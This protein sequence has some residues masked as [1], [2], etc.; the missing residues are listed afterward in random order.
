MFKEYHKIITAWKRD[1]VTKYKTLI[2]GEWA[3]PEFEYLQDAVWSWTEKV[4]GTNIRLT[5]ADG[6]VRLDGRHQRSQIPTDLIARLQDLFPESLLA[7]TFGTDGEIMLCGE[8]YGARIQKGGENYLP[9]SVDFIL[10][11]VWAGAW[12]ERE[13]VEDIAR[14]LDIKVVPIVGRGTLGGAIECVRVLRPYSQVAANVEHEM[15][16]LVM[17]P[18]VELLDRRGQRIITKIKVKDF[19]RR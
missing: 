3:T 1:P 9:D 5:W 12:L 11:D 4:D 10:F 15:E 14:K 16:G 13:N 2:W 17:R 6:V 18:E 8:G 7:E 19:S